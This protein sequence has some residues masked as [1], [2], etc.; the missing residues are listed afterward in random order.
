MLLELRERIADEFRVVAAD[1]V[2]SARLEATGQIVTVRGPS[3]FAAGIAELR[4]KL[5]T[6][7]KTLGIKAA[8]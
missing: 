2:I 1:P 3:E 6:T 4:A 5:A 8:Q 7:A